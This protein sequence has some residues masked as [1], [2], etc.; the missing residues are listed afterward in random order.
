MFNLNGKHILITGA[1]SGMGRVCAQMIA[2]QGAR[3]SLLS[4]NEERLIET[5]SELEGEGHQY[6]VCDLV[7]DCQLKKVVDIL[8]P[9]NGIVFCAGVNEF[10]PVKFIKQEKID[11]IFQTNYF[12]QLLLLKYILKKKLLNKGSS[13]IFISSVSSLLG[14]SGTLL[15]ASSKAAINSAVK[16]LASEFSSSKIRVNSICPGIIKTPMIEN[17]NIDETQFLE[18]ESKYPLGLGIPEDVGYAVIYHL[19]DESR[20]LTGNIMVLD[21]GF[22]LNK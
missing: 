6:Y 2:K 17:T 22:S 14:V 20:W 18:Q 3:V 12:S 5:L 10:L 9:L 11:H 8:T 7:D 4:R 13:L 21:G 1:S 15:Y 19:A 16:V